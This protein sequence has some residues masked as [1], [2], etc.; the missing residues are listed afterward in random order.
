M[1]SLIDEVNELI[2]QAEASG[3]CADKVKDAKRAKEDLSDAGS[4]GNGSIG[5]GAIIV[6]AG[7]VV[8]FFTGWTGIGALAGVGLAAAGVASVVSNLDL[9][10]NE[11]KKAKK[12]LQR[13]KDDLQ[14]CLG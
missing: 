7:V 10:A 4:A 6:V 1:P 2:R 11:M 13:A 12:E 8:G 9:K 14:E 3:R 5:V